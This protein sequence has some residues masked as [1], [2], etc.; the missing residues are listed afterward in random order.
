MD[1]KL[2]L[3]IMPELLHEKGGF[4]MQYPGFPVYYILHD[5]LLLKW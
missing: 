5:K 2:G 4:M 1:T 3:N